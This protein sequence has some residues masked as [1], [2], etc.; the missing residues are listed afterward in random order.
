MLRGRL[1]AASNYNILERLD[2]AATV[3]AEQRN[4]LAAKCALIAAG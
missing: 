3:M 2:I 1:L 4:S